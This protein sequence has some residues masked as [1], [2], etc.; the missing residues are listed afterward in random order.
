VYPSE[1]LQH[2][3]K[4]PIYSTAEPRPLQ[5]RY[6]SAKDESPLTS[7]ARYSAP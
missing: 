6:N 4:R 1:R 3:S 2:F 7:L 5:A